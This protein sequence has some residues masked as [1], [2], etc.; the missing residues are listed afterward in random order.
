MKTVTIHQAKSQLSKLIQDVVNGEE[1]I[2]A[3][4]SKPMVKLV[5]VEPEQSQRRIGS[6]KGKIHMT[7]DFDDE[8]EDFKDYINE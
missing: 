6:L 1:V 8:L 7:D 5:I 2:I 4:G 3:K